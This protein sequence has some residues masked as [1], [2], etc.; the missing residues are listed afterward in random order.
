MA[1][2]G[3]PGVTPASS[4][5]GTMERQVDQLQLEIAQ[6]RSL[7][8]SGRWW[9]FWTT[10]L[11]VLLVVAFT[12]A[13]YLKI[14]QNFNPDAVRQAVNARGTDVLPLAT[15]MLM[16]TGRDAMPAYQ[17]AMVAALQKRGPVMADTAYKR[18]QQ[19]PEE[20]GKLMQDK[21]QAAFAGAMG[22]IQP[23][24]KAAYPNLAD[25]KRQ[26]MIADFASKQIDA[27]N[28]SVASQINKLY[29]ND[30]I[31]LQTVLDKFQLPDESDPAATDQAGLERQF[32]H[33]MVALLDQQVDA[34]Y[35]TPVADAGKMGAATTR[36]AKQ[37]GPQ[38]SA[39]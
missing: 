12:L 21:L 37:P 4:V 5:L 31:Q 16:Q 29:T 34:A 30:L 1:E 36:P 27:Q 28:K 7:Q 39:R 32:M 17:A 13:T 23:Q 38:A 20:D 33:T 14:R 2:L 26:A 18:L 35:A 25:D 10:T 9:L 6:L 24:I 15:Q 22:Q 3:A 8:A 19:V 11:T